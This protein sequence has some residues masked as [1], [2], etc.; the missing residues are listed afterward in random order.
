M[1]T[2]GPVIV[3]TKHIEGIGPGL[4]KRENIRF[5]QPVLGPA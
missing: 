5:C 3:F 4:N 2:Y 1:N